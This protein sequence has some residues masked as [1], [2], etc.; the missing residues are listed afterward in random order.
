MPSD[1][2]AVRVVYAGVTDTANYRNDNAPMQAV[3]RISHFPA[4][5]RCAI[6]ARTGSI[7]VTTTKC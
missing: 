3:S 4:Q 6:C 2:M 5:I 1:P 7:C